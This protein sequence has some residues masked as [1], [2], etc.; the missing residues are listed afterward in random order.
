M[1][2]PSSSSAAGVVI[3]ASAVTITGSVFG[4]GYDAM[5][6]GLIGSLMLVMHLP[7][8]PIMRTIGMVFLGSLLSAG[9][10]PIAFAASL[11]YFTWASSISPTALRMACALLLGIVIPA[12]IPLGLAFSKRKSETL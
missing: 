8:A 9:F 5:I 2:D 11:S 6:G 10:A 3:G 4:L 1:T 7:A 12:I